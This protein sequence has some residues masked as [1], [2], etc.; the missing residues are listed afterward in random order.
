MIL[1]VVGGALLATGAFL[2]W[3][4]ASVNWDTISAVIGTI[5]AEVRS[6]GTVTVTGWDMAP[7]K[8]MLVTAIV[9]VIAPALLCRSRAAA[10]VVAFVMLFGGAVGGSMALYE[11]TIRQGQR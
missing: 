8:W 9:V 1:G 11:A 10:Q 2:N 5:P 4:T 6:Q 7:G 3:A